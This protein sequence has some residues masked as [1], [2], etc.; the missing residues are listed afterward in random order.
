MNIKT[1]SL[2]FPINISNS[3]RTMLFAGLS[4]SSFAIPFF[5]GY[6]QWLIG[7]II[8]TSLFLSAIF[9]PKKFF[10]PLIIFPSLGIL[11]K[12]IIFGPFTPF[13][14]YF[15]PFIWLG[16]L[17][18]IISFKQL[19]KFNYLFSLISAAAL[20]FLF[21]LLVANIYFQF[22]IVPKIFLTTMG[23]S[24]F[25]TALAGGIISLIIFNTWKKKR[26]K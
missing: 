26:P 23:V 24:Q 18:L 10:L 4:V 11:A 6:P 2:S 3:I 16:N 19:Y 8:N 21:L 9:F 20:K 13:L 25:F 15:L 22:A 17:I 7:T 12:G 5:L 1:I 14:V